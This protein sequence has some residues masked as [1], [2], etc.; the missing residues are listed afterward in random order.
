MPTDLHRLAFLSEAEVQFSLAH[1][2]DT[3][4]SAQDLPRYITNYIGSKQKLVDWIWVHTPDGVKSV[5]D[6]F[7][8]S[9]VV[10]YMYKS[11]GL[12]V[13]TNDRLHYCHHIAKAIIENSSITISEDELTGLL[14]ANSKAGDFVQ[15][16]FRGKFFQ[17]GV[18]GIIDTIRFNIDS[19]KGFKKDIALFALGKT[20]ISAAGSYGHF[21][22]ASR[23]SGGSRADTPKEFTDRFKST[24]IRTNE[25]IFDNGQKNRALRKGVLEVLPDADVDLAYFDPPYA[26][27][28]STTNYE[29]TYH[30]IEGLMT[31]WKGLEIDE[32]SKVKKFVNNHQTVTQSNAEEFFDGFLGKAKGIKHWIIS[33]RDHAY[34]NE[35]KM[36]KL[37]EH[38]GKSSSM[39]SKDHSYSMAGQ[40]RA[41]DAS[42]GK[43]HLFICSPKSSTKAELETEP[44]TTVADMHG[45]AKDSNDR[46]TA[47]MGSK[48]DML[49]WIWKNTPEGVNSVCD[50]FSGGANVAYF[51]KRKGLRVIANDILKYPYHIT[52]AVVENS[53]VTLS[54]EDIEALIKPNSKAKT[55]ITDTF[56]GYYYT[57]PILEFLDHTY[58]NIQQLTGYK[59]DIA[60]FALG[61]T[62]QI[63]A[64]FGEF[65]RSKKSMTAPLPDDV[66]KYQNSHL[67]NP[68]LSEFTQL[69][70]KCI[71]DA[72]A[73]V[74]DNGQQ[75]KAYNQR[76]LSLLPKIKVD[77]VYADPPY[78][79]QFGFNDYED[80]MHF[81]EGLMTYWEGKEVQDNT[82]RNY[83]SSTKYNKD[84]I[85]E[86]ITGF[87][88]ESAKIGA[89]LMMS[90][91]DKAFPTAA[92]LKGMFGGRFGSV[93]FRRRSISYNIARYA[94]EGSGRDAQEYLLIGSKPKAMKT[95]ADY[96]TGQ[97][98]NNIH[99]AFHTLLTGEIITTDVPNSSASE[100]DKR[101][102]F[103]LVH[104]G[105]NRNGDHFTAEELKNNYR[106]AVNT[107]IDL[108]H[109]QDLTDIVG[110]VIDAR[111]AETDNGIIECDGE[112]YTADNVHAQLAYKL[113]KKGIVQ[114]VSMECDYEEGECSICH[115]RFKSKGEYC[116]HLKKY[117]GSNYQ[118]KPVYEIL[119]NIT[120]TG[121]GLLDRQGADP[122]AKIVSI[123]NSNG[124]KIMDSI[125]DFGSYLTAKKIN[126]E[127]WP[128]TSALE[129]YISDLLKKFGNE[130]ITQDVLTNQIATSL[131]TFRT[132]MKGLVD[133]V[134][135]DVTN[136]ASA[137]NDEEVK[138]LRKEND[139]L[140]KQL[141]ELQK[142]L[143]A[144]E[145]EKQKVARKTRASEL[146]LLWEKRGRK[147]KD[148]DERNTEL[149]RLAELDDGSFA[150]TKS[151]IDSLPETVDSKVLRSD[152]GI[153]P[154]VVDDGADN[155]GT[156]LSQ[157]LCEVRETQNG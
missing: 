91:R 83:A 71:R 9:A 13:V 133:Q 12:R 67:G 111:F 105:T 26:T 90:Y 36:K 98:I 126:N 97:S 88:D 75:C 56:Y 50:L 130:D 52:R 103:I 2:D 128:L 15:E 96:R 157:G 74:F 22:S 156:R 37:I 53:S 149:E 78:M 135:S 136:Q 119:H 106:T 19:L 31:Y 85:T 92:E 29:S 24:I 35:A 8:G 134:K 80:K 132:K 131:D 57:K 141:E 40:N 55:F 86:L 108:K 153:T 42:H 123:A 107:K 68:T 23:G 77:F 46:V 100:G 14:K 6:A 38:H 64:C 59:K 99:R 63:R 101:F 16:T 11:K 7:S 60:M 41:G 69:F 3:I 87:V 110:G 43:E 120:F 84:S 49:D 113:I 129:G 32:S 148:D 124:D 27:E 30:F 79:T 82:R 95:A 137:A 20:C 94:K 109:S 143:D 4:E 81:V 154:A 125:A 51:Y 34:P 89:Q 121:M 58:A 21:G 138:Q 151:V 155:L 5:L 76:S 102:S 39:R 10:A 104:T 145:A 65:S 1:Q 122:E 73:L 44:F 47:F 93:D 118:N 28:F 117:K 114:Q 147:F 152:A 139:S 33:Y 144:Y 62:C 115:K 112:L 116:I 146:I 54:D 66:V 72:N 17:S 45:N 140:K 61:R 25:L 142:T 48:H 127:V 18:H 150:A 70:V